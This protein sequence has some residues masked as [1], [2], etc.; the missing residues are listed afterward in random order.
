MIILPCEVSFYPFA[1]RRFE[2]ILCSRIIWRALW[3]TNMSL[4]IFPL[5]SPL[6]S[7]HNC[8]YL[9]KGTVDCV[10][11]LPLKHQTKD[12]Q[13]GLLLKQIW[14][15][16]LLKNGWFREEL[17]ICKSLEE[18]WW[19]GRYKWSAT[20]HSRWIRNGTTRRIYY[21]VR[22]LKCNF[23]L[24]YAFASSYCLTDYL[25]CALCV[26]TGIFIAHH[27]LTFYCKKACAW[28]TYFF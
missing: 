4:Q 1:R 18:G 20:D 15:L 22:F 14:T 21:T 28:F 11:R 24:R 23:F 27:Q 13:E 6:K 25:Q 5:L 19:W 12:L 26:C 16:N 2:Y 7:A 8:V 17:R 3:V 9:S 10:A